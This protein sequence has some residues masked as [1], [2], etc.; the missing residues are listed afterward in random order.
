MFDTH[1]HL[2]LEEFN[3]D[4][5][6]A[7]QRAKGKGIKYILLPN[8]D[9]TTIKSL[10]DTCNDFPDYCLPAMGLHPT[11]VK[12]NYRD[13]LTIVEQ[14]LD[15]DKFYAIGETG[16][17]LY[18]DKTYFEQQKLAFIRQTELAI[19]F[20]LPIII[21]SRNSLDELIALVEKINNPSLKGIFHCFP[22][23]SE[24]AKKVI[25]LGFK[26]GIGGVVTYNNSGM[27]QVVRDIE[28]REIVLETDSPYLPPVPYRGRRNESSYLYFI[29]EKISQIKD[30][31]F[32]SVAEITTDNAIKLFGLI[33]Y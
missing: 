1:S 22:G 13:E 25:D 30:I 14:W 9:S 8:V 4:R 31:S 28:L 15:K 29:A 33:S 18:W 23:D 10:T 19:N 17:D 32:D 12:D 16:I 24:Q 21:H 5:K 6:E 3:H 7:I 27:Q 26:I 2:F 11:S 20:K